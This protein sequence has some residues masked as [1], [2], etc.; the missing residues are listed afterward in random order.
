M[1]L[2][3]LDFTTIG[4]YF[5]VLLGFGI[6]VRRVR[7]FS[8]YAVGNR[9]VPTSM[10]F[11][12]LSAAYI[13][14]GYT[15][16]FCSKGFASGYFFFFIVLAFTVQTLLVGLFLAPRLHNFERCYSIGD[17]LGEDR[18]LKDCQRMDDL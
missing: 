7:G 15:M 18:P 4:I 9:E 8:D 12:S 17:V 6:L 14:P 13:G 11:A 2:N 10:I 3:F 1:N 16:G 5:L